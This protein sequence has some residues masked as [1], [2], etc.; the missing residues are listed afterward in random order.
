LSQPRL[1]PESF[2]ARKFTFYSNQGWEISD[3]GTI[4]SV[5]NDFLIAYPTTNPPFGGGP[6]IRTPGE[7]DN[8]LRVTLK[9][10]RVFTE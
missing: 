3:F 9:F 2:D 6:V 10:I 1:T 8:G 7:F 4:G 5:E